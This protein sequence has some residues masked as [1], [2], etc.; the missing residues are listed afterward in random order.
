MIKKNA[1]IILLFLLY[2]GL[3]LLS[4]PC[5]ARATD[6]P[7]LIVAFEFNGKL[8]SVKGKKIAPHSYL[9]NEGASKKISITTLDWAPYIGETICGQGWVQ[10]LTI[11]LL[12]SLGYEIK[13]TFLPWARAVA[14]VE[15]GDTD[16]LYPEYYIEPSAPSD[17][18]AGTKRLEHLALSK[19]FPGGPLAFMKRKG[20]KDGF[21]GNLLNLKN[22]KIGVVRGYQNSPEFDAYM[23]SGF[24]N[25]SEAV[26]DLMN[27]KKLIGNRTNMIIGDPAVI[28]FSISSSSLSADEK[29]DMLGKIEVVQPVI[30]Y[31]PLYFAVSR[32]KPSWE[33]T[34]EAINSM[35]GKFERSGLLFNIIQSTNTTCGYPMEEVLRPYGNQ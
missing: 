26:D 7:S 20:E 33:K 12:S 35:L 17:V 9:F 14:T 18:Y 31:N 34:L 13:S 8:F 23:D 21:K 4:C 25:I 3:V 29:S 1:A 6:P 32:K 27:V 10:Q 5:P 2:F 22:E 11:A 16:L 15:S 19:K 30:L 24:F 28:V